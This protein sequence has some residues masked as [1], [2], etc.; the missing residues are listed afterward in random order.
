VAAPER[1]SEDERRDAPVEGWAGPPRRA[2]ANPARFSPAVL[3]RVAFLGSR[4][5]PSPGSRKIFPPVLALPAFGAY[6]S[7]STF[8]GRENARARA[9]H[10][11]CSKKRLVR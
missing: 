6:R 8:V 7:Y 5:P 1:R 2:A 10:G 3:I 9:F 4:S 11:S